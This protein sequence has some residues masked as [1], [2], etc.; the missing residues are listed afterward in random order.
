MIIQQ[1]TTP[2]LP[3]YSHLKEWKSELIKEMVGK[4]LKE[5]RTPSLVIDKTIL[6][7]NCN[8][9]S[10]ITTELNTK[11]R[12]HVKTHKTV[13][14]AR[15]QL[16]NTKTD[17]IV[18]STLAEAYAMIDSTLTKSGLLKD[19]L[20]GFP[21]TPDKFNDVIELSKR[22]NTFQIFI[23]DL[24]TLEALEAFCLGKDY[25]FNTF[26]KVNCGYSRAGVPLNDVQ[27]IE[28]AKR[29][30]AS[31]HIN[32]IGIYTHAGHSYSSETPEKALEYLQEECNIA[33]QFRDYFTNHGIHIGYVSIGA[34]PTVKAIIA[35]LESID[36]KRVLEGIDEVHAG[37]YAF[38]DKQ[39][40]FTGL[41]NYCDVAITV[42]TRVV[43]HYK[44]RNSILIDAGG[45]AFSKDTAP[46]GGYGYVL[47]HENGESKILA[48][49]SKLS[50][51]HGLLQELDPA[52][53][54]RPEFQIGEVIR[55]IPNHCCLAAA[56]HLF[57]LII[58]N[59]SDI[60]VDVWVPIKGW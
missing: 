17:A 49:V 45:L 6:E 56:C 48:S 37:A 51:E 35:F 47:E 25:K 59:G 34:T 23:D 58:E 32:F 24:Q 18:V 5:L 40:V 41:G 33:R 29:L 12:V 2:L 30:Q 14:G 7:R 42:A 43:S 20:L 54:L 38:L 1:T 11:V 13:E 46:Q 55:V 57:Y 9:L 39:Q 60:V 50:Q 52:I 3:F 19:V 4:K 21:I 15:I 8:K 53:L 31:P 27:S 10:K 44:D 16:E 26:L 28:L 36:M 22:V